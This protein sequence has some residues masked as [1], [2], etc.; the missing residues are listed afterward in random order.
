VTEHVV[1]TALERA[2]TLGHLDLVRVRVRVRVSVKVRV[3]VRGKG[4]G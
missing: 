2:Q 1:G 4:E 3:R